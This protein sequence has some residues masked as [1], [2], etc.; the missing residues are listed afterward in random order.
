[1][2]T[3]R[4]GPLLRAAEDEL[5]ARVAW[6]RLAEPGDP[7][8]A[9]LVAA[10]GA[11]AALTAL[12]ERDVSWMAKYRARM[13][14]VHPVRDIESIQRLGGRVIIPSDMQWPPGCAD[15]AVPPLCLWVR[16]PLDVD[17]LGV[18]SVSI[19]GARAASAYGEHIAAEFGY[20]MAAADY[21]V[22]SGL[23]FG[24]DAAVHRA[25]LA[26]GLSAAVLAGGLERAYPAAHDRLLDHLCA[27]G[28]VCSEVPVGVAP[29]R[30]RFLLR[31]RLIAAMTSGTIVVEAAARSGAL[32]TARTA[33]DLGRP[34]G[35]APGPV[36]AA[37][38]VGCHQLIRSGRAAL[39]TSAA[40]ILDLVG[41]LGQDAA[42]EV[43]REGRITDQLAPVELQVLDALS[44]SRGRSLDR[45]CAVAGVDPQAAHRALAQL[46][47]LGFAQRTASGW[48]AQSK[49]GAPPGLA[50]MN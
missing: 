13:A 23:A 24:I 9:E 22:L 34:V 12:W 6:S 46:A 28:M 15:L 1:M 50:D 14:T 42:P 20:G 39:I 47:V 36:T 5:L 45:I 10:V 11:G 44:Q 35:A 41:R 49:R 48:R 18:R 19:V 4:P 8:L 33:A 40:E 38:S 2:S 32:N 3:Q 30:S 7:R 31:N 29:T 37:A 17:Q 26:G 21:V 16:G 25:A 43:P 27:E